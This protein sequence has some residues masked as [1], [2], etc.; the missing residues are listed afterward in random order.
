MPVPVQ[1]TFR[2]TNSS[3]DIEALI[4]KR[5]AKLEQVYDRLL[6]CKVVIDRPHQ[7]KKKGASFEITIHLSVPGKELAVSRSRSDEE[8]HTLMNSAIGDAFDAALREL[9]EFADKQ[10]HHTAA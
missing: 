7:H 6:G 3:D 9:K 4:H 2:H 8:S 5:V 10:R 1:I